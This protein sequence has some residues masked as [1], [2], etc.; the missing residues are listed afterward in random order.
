MRIFFLRISYNVCHAHTYSN[1]AFDTFHL[2]SNNDRT[3][4]G[5]DAVAAAAAGGGG[6][7]THILMTSASRWRHGVAPLDVI[8]VPMSSSDT[9]RSVAD[10]PTIPPARRGVL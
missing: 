5:S 10:R 3:E 2:S 4:H 9:S 7:R 6:V 8:T 1:C